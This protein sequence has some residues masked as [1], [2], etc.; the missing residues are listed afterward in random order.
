MAPSLRWLS[1]VGVAL[2]VATGWW[3]NGA[4]S[5]LVSTS[6]DE[7]LDHG[8]PMVQVEPSPL[9]SPTELARSQPSAGPGEV[10]VLPVLAEVKARGAVAQAADHKVWTA[11]AV[12]QAYRRDPLAL[13]RQLQDR[14]GVFTGTILRL[15]FGESGV[16]ILSLGH[17]DVTWNM[18]LSPEE[19]AS[20]PALN[21][22]QTVRADCMGQGLVM[23]LLVLVD[24]RLFP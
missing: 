6:F 8:R 15:E 5:P 22:G 19:A 21:P 14:R 12:A 2:C 11:P 20:V 16:T 4:S 9:P 7:P 17:G 13:A 10:S 24:C 1:V 23:G 3:M 18:V